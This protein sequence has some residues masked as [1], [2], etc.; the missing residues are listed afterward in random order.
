MKL[1]LGGRNYA[2]FSDNT[3]CKLNNVREIKKP[4]ISDCFAS[5]I[6]SSVPLKQASSETTTSLM[7]LIFETKVTLCTNESIEIW[8]EITPRHE[9]PKAVYLPLTK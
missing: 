8:R 7:I 1:F 6:Y 9:M 4:S 3:Q 2:I 5:K